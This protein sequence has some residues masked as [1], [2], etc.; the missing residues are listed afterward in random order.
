MKNAK[1]VFAAGFLLAVLAGCFNPITT[2]A[3]VS[4]PQQQEEDGPASFTVDILIGDD[5]VDGR[6]LAGPSTEQLGGLYNFMELV[7]MNGSTKDITVQQKSIGDAGTALSIT[8][9][10]TSATYNFLL[11]MGHKAADGVPSLLAA[12][13]QSQTIGK[14]GKI[15]ITMWPIEVE[16]DF[17][18]PAGGLALE[19]ADEPTEAKLPGAGAWTVRWTLGGRAGKAVAA[20]LAARQAASPGAAAVFDQTDL[21]V[22]LKGVAITGSVAGNVVT[23]PLGDLAVGDTGPVFFNLN[24]R[25][26]NLPGN[27]LWIFR[28]GVNDNAQN[29]YTDFSGPAAWGTGGKNGNGAVNF[30]V[31]QNSGGTGGGG[32][33]DDDL[34][35]TGY[36]DAPAAYATAQAEFTAKWY[37]G[38]IAWDNSVNAGKSTFNPEVVYTATLTLSTAAAGGFTGIKANSFSHRAAITVTNAANPSTVTIVFRATPSDLSDNE[39]SCPFSGAKN[40]ATGSIIDLITAKKS[41]ASL[42]LEL[43]DINDELVQ[44][45]ATTDLGTTEWVL[46]A[47]STSPAHLTIDGGDRVIDLTGSPVAAPAPLITVNSGVTLVLRNITF[48]GLKKDAA[49]GEANNTAPVI[50]VEGGTLILGTGAVICDNT[51]EGANGIDWGGTTGAGAAGTGGNDGGHGSY[52]PAGTGGEGVIGGVLVSG[53]TFIMEAGVEISDNGG[54]SAAAPLPAGC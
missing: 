4:P 34:D 44:F 15:T 16:T 18:H 9:L 10:S 22:N 30:T 8:G 35:L 51:S 54:G 14:S 28:N 17:I 41:L 26:F 42:T 33:E 23:A 53:G 45:D 3:P 12:G 6:F 7:V 20:L 19:K 36:I 31:V 40:T 37:S 50:A 39:L 52:G 38:T 21:T 2:E 49:E 48:K 32:T 27:S 46:T 5:A 25:A 11:L 29:T 1:R 24:Y 47:N 13:L 43:K